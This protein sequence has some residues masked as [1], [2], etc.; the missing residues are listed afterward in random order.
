MSYKKKSR[1]LLI[2]AGLILLIVY[3][4]GISN[5]LD[6]RR[7]YDDQSKKAEEISQMPAEEQRL[8]KEVAVMEAGVR[9]YV[10]DSSEHQQQ[11]LDL[12]AA[13][14]QSHETVLREFPKTIVAENGE[15]QVE[16]NRFVVQ[17]SFQALLQLVYS[18]E[19]KHRIGRVGSVCYQLVKEIKTKKM[20][21][22]ATVYLQNIKKKTA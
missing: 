11:L 10:Q 19:Q 20:V 16:T 3:R 21:L 15:L 9:N 7:M 22:T 13:Y 14:C 18:L 1:L 5:T 6:L 2:G 4:F 8:K 17:G 12:L